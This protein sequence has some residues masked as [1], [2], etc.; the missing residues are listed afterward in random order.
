MQGA[1]V[2]LYRA[3]SSFL[4]KPTVPQYVPACLP[5][6]SM[7]RSQEEVSSHHG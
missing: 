3:E 6:F 4:V 7:Q 5:Q 2:K 1:C